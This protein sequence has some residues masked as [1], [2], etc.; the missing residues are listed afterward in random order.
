MKNYSLVISA[1]NDNDN[2]FLLKIFNSNLRHFS[3][4][5]LLKYC[6]LNLHTVNIVETFLHSKNDLMIFPLEVVSCQ[7][8]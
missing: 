4:L 3:L 2:L 5:L 1:N 8:F 6:F 7:S